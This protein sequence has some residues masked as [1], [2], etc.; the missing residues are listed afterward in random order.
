MSN[1]QFPSKL[2]ERAVSEC[3]KLPG[4]GRRTALRLVLH[5]LG[6]SSD[7]VHALAD[8]LVRLRDE[9]K[10]CKVCHNISDTDVCDICSNA[11]RDHSVIC[12]VENVRGVLS[13]ENT[14]QFYGVYH[15]LGGVISP[16]DGIGPAD[17]E[18]DSLIER[19]SAGGVEEVILA[20]NP[21]MEGDTTIFYIQRRLAEFPVRLSVLSRGVS[22]GDELEFTDEVTL[23]R[24]IADRK[25]LK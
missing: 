16:V 20:L 22:V 19:V 13:I 23:G 6:Q 14:G 1:E 12:V 2:L 25:T 11:L 15:V 17:L 4:I 3:A 5:L 10:Y 8:S 7:A 24:S 9:V 21:T 18:L